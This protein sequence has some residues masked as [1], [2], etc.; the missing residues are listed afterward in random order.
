MQ[1]G[2]QEG[3]A[4]LSLQPL[5]LPAGPPHGHPAEAPTDHLGPCIAIKT[6]VPPQRPWRPQHL[7][8]GDIVPVSNGLT[9]GRS[10][11]RDGGRYQGHVTWVTHRSS[12][13][14]F[15]LSPL[16]HLL[17]TLL[18]GLTVWKPSQLY[19]LSPPGAQV[20]TPWGWRKAGETDPWALV[21]PPGRPPRSQVPKTS[22]KFPCSAPSACLCPGFPW[23]QSPATPSSAAGTGCWHTLLFSPSVGLPHLSDPQGRRVAW[24]C[25]PAGAGVL[26][27]EQETAQESGWPDFQARLGPG[28]R[29]GKPLLQL[30][31][32]AFHLAGCLRLPAGSH[33]GLAQYW[34][35]KMS[36]SHYAMMK[37]RPRKVKGLA[38]GHR[39]EGDK[40]GFF[41]PKRAHG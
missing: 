10:P 25:C 1:V 15:I 31:S 30:S 35:W 41:I 18:R 23:K 34:S 37:V 32:E 28:R 12:S 38:Q 24:V 17:F 5:S 11:R 26:P 21:Q 39:L 20:G 16:N 8:C 36:P 33:K 29:G 27:P 13:T 3:A 14:P 19:H 7:P 6:L 40:V 22:A 9:D 2:G 4:L